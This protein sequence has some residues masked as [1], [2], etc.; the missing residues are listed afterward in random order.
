MNWG[1]FNEED[2]YNDIDETDNG[3]LCHALKIVLNMMGAV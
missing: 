1:M 2:K 3:F